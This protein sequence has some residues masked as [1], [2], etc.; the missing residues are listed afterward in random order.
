MAKDYLVDFS[1]LH[2]SVVIQGDINLISCTDQRRINQNLAHGISFESLN[3]FIW[4][5]N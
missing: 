5:L 1:S 3:I 2:V 4:H